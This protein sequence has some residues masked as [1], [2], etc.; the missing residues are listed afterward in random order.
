MKLQNKVALIT[1][2]GSGMGQAQ[3]LLFA[4]EGAKVVAVDVNL[5]SVEETVRQIE[6]DGGEALA[7]KGDIS[8]KESVQA[9]VKLALKEYDRIDILSN[10][11]GVLDD[12]A[13]TLET[14]EALWDKIIGINLKGAYLMTNEVLPQMLDRGKGTIM[15]VA[16]IAAMVAGG[17]GAA[18]TA[19]KHG[20][21]GY[22]KQLSF[23]YGKKGIKANAICPGAVST[24]MTEEILRD[25]D[26][27]VMESIKG[28][29]AG[30]YAQPE[31]IANL[32]LFLA[33]DESDFIHGAVMPIDGGWTV[34]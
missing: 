28:V 29:P 21:V 25:E 11:A 34:Q 6:A 14:D 13:P 22:T 8:K 15:N 17:G 10:T 24:G 32:A 31:E 7:L 12:Y 9:L 33:S 26:A 18:Y 3:A 27:P 19:S 4:K 2:A 23:D 5:Q 16:S 1:G 30:R 20:L